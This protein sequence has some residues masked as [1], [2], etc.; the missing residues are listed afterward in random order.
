MN[1]KEVIIGLKV[2]TNEAAKLN[3]LR[4]R[5]EGVVTGFTLVGM[6]KVCWAGNDTSS[7]LSSNFLEPAP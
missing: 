7:T 5:S 2:R 3:G 4:P 6:P 1:S